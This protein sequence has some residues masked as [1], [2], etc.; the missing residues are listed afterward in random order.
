MESVGANDH[1]IGKPNPKRKHEEWF[2]DDNGYRNRSRPFP[3]NGYD[4]IVAGDFLIVGAFL[5]QKDIL[6]EVLERACECLVYNLGGAGS[7][8]HVESDGFIEHPARFFFRDVQL[9]PVIDDNTRS[10]V[11]T[12]FGYIKRSLG[13]L[14]KV[15]ASAR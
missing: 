7:Y 14:A 12:F 8:A 9:N 3:P 2:T 10:G 11:F 15:D 1:S 13:R 4:V 5:D 6:S